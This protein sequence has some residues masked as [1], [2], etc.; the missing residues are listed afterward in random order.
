MNL[1][2][3]F[4][5]DRDLIGD[6]NGRWLEIRSHYLNG[7]AFGGLVGTASGFAK[8]LQDQL[9]ARSVL[10][11]DTT[12]QLL[13]APQQTMRGTPVAMTLGW[14]IGD[15]DGPRFFYKEGGGGGFHCM[16]RV[17]PGDGIGTVV[18]TNATGFDVRRLLD[19]IDASFLRSAQAR[20]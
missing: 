17:Y 10:F 16:M 20:Q 1:V 12:R 9:R 4:L 7:P 15:L 5:I 2:K 19:A 6:Y 8:F 11:N 13:Y 3:G 14:H 18:M